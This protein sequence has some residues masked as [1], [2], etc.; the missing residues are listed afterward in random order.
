[1]GRGSFVVGGV[2]EDYPRLGLATEVVARLRA[3]QQEQGQMLYNLIRLDSGCMW[4]VSQL[5]VAI[6]ISKIHTLP[7]DRQVPHP[8]IK[9]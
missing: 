2:R 4:I 1:M 7:T 9:D 3:N 6:S 8:L 5:E